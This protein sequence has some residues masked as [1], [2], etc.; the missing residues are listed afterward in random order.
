MACPTQ[1]PSESRKNILKTC[2]GNSMDLSRSSQLHCLVVQKKGPSQS[3]FQIS[4]TIPPTALRAI[5][6]G[7]GIADDPDVDDYYTRTWLPDHLFPGRWPRSNRG[8]ACCCGRTEEG[9]DDIEHEAGGDSDRESLSEDET[10]GDEGEDRAEEDW[11]DEDANIDEASAG[12]S[13]RKQKQKTLSSID[14]VCGSF[15]NS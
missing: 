3:T 10:T 4:H 8:D 9:G 11:V 1:H 7:M 2:C 15:V 12:P 14:K 5:Y 13:K 6:S